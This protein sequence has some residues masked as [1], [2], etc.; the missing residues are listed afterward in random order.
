MGWQA[1]ESPATPNYPLQRTASPPLGGAFV[2]VLLMVDSTDWGF[3]KG[4]V[5][6]TLRSIL[7]PALT[8]HEVEAIVVCLM[9]HLLVENRIN[10]VLYRWLKR[11][12]PAPNDPE[13]TPKT[14]DALWNSIVKIDFAKKYSLIE[15]F[16]AAHFPAEASDAWKINDLRNDIFHGRR[17]VQ[18]A[19]FK[20]Q[21]ISEEQTVQSIFLAAQFVSMQL[22]KFDEL[23]DLPHA[24]AERWAKRLREMGEPLL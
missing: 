23:V 3:P 24:H 2:G 18:D 4:R 13:Q 9:A 21:P 16:F 10:E 6:R 5:A 7:D 14:A 20:G 17:A 1:M 12:A 15:P 22:D 19:K 8:D 11:D